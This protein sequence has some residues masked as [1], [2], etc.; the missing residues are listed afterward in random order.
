MAHN[1]DL[2]NAIKARVKEMASE[3][4]NKTLKEEV[5]PVAKEIMQ[6]NIQEKFYDKYSPKVYERRG[7]SGGLID[8]DNIITKVDGNRI[9]IANITPPSPSIFGTPIRSNDPTLLTSWIDD[10]VIPTEMFSSVGHLGGEQTLEEH[11]SKPSFFEETYYDLVGLNIVEDIIRKNL[12]ED[13]S[14]GIK[15]KKTNKVVK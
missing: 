1:K 2:Y 5:A 14:N 12:K 11:F 13:L 8:E 4:I 10:G 7:N 6:K 9:T 3:S 15:M